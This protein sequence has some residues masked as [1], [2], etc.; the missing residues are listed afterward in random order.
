MYNQNLSRARILRLILALIAVALLVLLGIWGFNAFENRNLRITYTGVGGDD[1][2]SP[3][4]IWTPTYNITF[5]KPLS[6]K[7]LSVSVN[8]QS[9]LY[10]GGEIKSGYAVYGDNLSVEVNVPLSSNDTYT[11]TINYIQDDSGQIMINKQVTF[12]PKYITEGSALADSDQAE[13]LHARH[14]AFSDPILSHLPYDNLYFSLTDTVTSEANG[15]SKLTL[16]ATLY[17]NQADMSDKNAAI[18]EGKQQVLNYI[19]S[20]GLNPA[21]YTIIYN[22]IS[23]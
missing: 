17:L 23:P 11:I 2:D 9:S 4:T 12:K 15:S 8:P 5:N 21:N 13:A 20:L 18:T 7:D 22:V 1:P 10:T 3:M 6:S 14:K 16:N 19:S